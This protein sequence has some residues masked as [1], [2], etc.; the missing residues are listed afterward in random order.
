MRL[1]W[2]V[3]G[4]FLISFFKIIYFPHRVIVG[5]ERGFIRRYWNTYNRNTR[6]SCLRN[7]PKV[8]TLDFGHV[9]FAFFAL[10]SGMAFCMVFL[11]VE[12]IAQWALEKVPII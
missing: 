1:S 11:V 12:C 9:F 2:R 8:T 4:I 10:W 3:L 6:L 7:N 5:L